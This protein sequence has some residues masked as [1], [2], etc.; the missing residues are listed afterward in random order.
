MNTHI[1]KILRV[2]ERD[3]AKELKPIVDKVAARLMDKNNRYK[4]NPKD[5]PMGMGYE[6]IP[7]AELSTIIQPKEYHVYKIFAS[8]IDL[9]TG[10]GNC[11]TRTGRFLK[12]LHGKNLECESHASVELHRLIQ[13]GRID[14]EK[15]ENN[16][17]ISSV[18]IA[19]DVAPDYSK[20]SLEKYSYV[21]DD[22]F[23]IKPEIDRLVLTEEIEHKFKPIG[24]YIEREVMRMHG[25]L[26]NKNNM[27]MLN[28]AKSKNQERFIKTFGT[29]V[30]VS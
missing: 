18:N 8:N 25:S 3:H 22:T 20:L 2:L 26:L 1:K 19:Q 6:L 14:G 13:E 17:Y 16:L 10:E 29:N 11:N 28:E 4:I 5:T 23:Y 9:Y 21:A 12:G 30:V 24:I 7:L 15:L 27:T